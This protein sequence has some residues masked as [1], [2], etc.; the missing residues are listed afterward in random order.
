MEIARIIATDPKF[1]LLDEPF[2]GLDP[3]S[4]KE[5]HGIV[6]K[7]KQDNIGILITDHNASA[8]MELCDRIYFLH[9]GKVITSGLPKDIINHEVISK[10]YFG[11]NN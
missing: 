8:M 10:A 6:N 7:L 4:I 3:K 1:L 2:A 5:F 11:I 9:K